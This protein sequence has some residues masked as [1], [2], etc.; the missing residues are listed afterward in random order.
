METLLTT[1][2]A[3]AAPRVGL[4]S[5]GLD[6]YWP[7]FPGLEDR[8]N[9]YSNRIARKLEALGA[10]V[11]HLGLID[12]PRKAAQAGHRF[13]QA[14][15]DLIFL[16]IATY[17]LSSTVLPVVRRA[18][19]PVVI[20]NLAPAPAIDYD[21]FNRSGDRAKMTG[22]WLAYCQACPAPEIANVFSRCRIPF[23][24]V[25]GLLEDDA[26]AWRE[27]EEWVAAP[28]ENPCPD[29]FSRSAIRIAGTAFHWALGDSS[30]SGAGTA[31][32]ITAPWASDA[33]GQ[34]WRSSPPCSE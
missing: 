24:Q 30:M 8:L 11:V 29:R 2:H 33:W 6:A 27:I 20:L 28:R 34:S 4:F 14:D 17:A 9:G 18:R 25:T 32:R 21:A 31:P 23:F 12:N 10:E 7:Q 3:S 16:H 1:Q 13:R 22:E 19:V 5:I 26:A 15:V